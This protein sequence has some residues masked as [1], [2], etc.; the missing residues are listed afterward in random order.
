MIKY[1]FTDDQTDPNLVSDELHEHPF[2]ALEFATG[3]MLAQV[4]VVRA[5]LKQCDATEML[6]AFAILGHAQPLNGRRI[7]HHLGDLFL[8]RHSGDQVVHTLFNGQGEF[9]IR[10]VRIGSHVLLLKI[11]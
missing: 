5:V 4:N 8:Q 11:K 3:S 10:R 1:I 6:W 9:L 2:D 7:V